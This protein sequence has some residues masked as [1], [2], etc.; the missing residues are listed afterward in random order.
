MASAAM[1]RGR[2]DPAPQPPPI[3]IKK[4]VQ[5]AHGAHHG[6]AWK[7][8]Y[9]DFVTAMMAFFLLLWLL[10]ATDEDQRRGLADYFTPTLIEYKQNSAGSNGI[11]GGDSIVA[12]DNYPHRAGQ[13]GSRA[14]TIPRDVTGGVQEGAVPRNQID[15]EEFR[16]LSAELRR[17]IEAS[18]ELRRLGRHV[19]FAESDEGLRID[20]MDEGDFSMFRV[21]T[22]QL[23]PPAQRLVREVAQVI[24]GVP[25][26]VIIRGHTDSLPYAAGRTTN[27]WTLSA[28][29]AE[30]TRGTLEAAGVPLARIARIE[31]VADRQP[32]VAN[33]R[34]DPRN[35]RISITL[36][37]RNGTS[38]TSARPTTSPPTPQAGA[39]PARPAH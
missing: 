29:R 36:G 27:N 5:E 1:K 39:P 33:N 28:A 19:S 31:G 8:A 15:R 21:G 14:I 13:T 37:W 30:S 22:D 23:L 18:P 17:R 24:S 34:Y 9:A 25:N 35:R 2:N 6:G 3:I 16:R 20:L 7:I 26:N 4:V 32:Y 12:A 10:G 38:S 11:L